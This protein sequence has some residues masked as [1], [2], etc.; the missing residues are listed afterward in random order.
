MRVSHRHVCLAEGT[1]DGAGVDSE[2][3]SD[4][5]QRPALI[6]KLSGF[7]ESTGEQVLPSWSTGALDVFHDSRSADVELRSQVVDQLALGV[8][9]DE[10]F[11]VVF[12]Q[13]TV[14][15]MGRPGRPSG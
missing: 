6:V 2:V 1:P 10:S 13:S 3:P 9:V 5:G 15:S 8:E 11:D 4:S 14:K 12:A 7:F